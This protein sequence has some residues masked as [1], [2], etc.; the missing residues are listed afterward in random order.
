MDQ[1]YLIYHVFVGKIEI[2]EY[3]E[4]LRKIEN[5]TLNKSHTEAT[6]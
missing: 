6:D 4:V 1:L 3:W 5:I 2:Y